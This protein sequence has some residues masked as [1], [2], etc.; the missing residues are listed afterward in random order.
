MDIGSEIATRMKRIKELKRLQSSIPDPEKRFEEAVKPRQVLE[1]EVMHLRFQAADE[2]LH[3][4]RVE[5]DSAVAGFIIR[6]L[7]RVLAEVEREFQRTDLYPNIRN[8]LF[9]RKRSLETV[10][11]VL[12]G[13]RGAEDMVASPMF[14]IIA[15]FDDD[16]MDFAEASDEAE[17]VAWEAHFQAQG[18]V[19]TTYLAL[20]ESGNHTTLHSPISSDE[21]QFEDMPVEVM[22]RVIHAADGKVKLPP[23]LVNG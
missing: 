4:Q 11:G 12:K 5:V 10:V 2:P 17:R 23:H 16:S 9:H 20:P 7:R 1:D 18:G 6:I 13:K 21:N 22:R 8:D 19:T 3:S 15:E 14:L